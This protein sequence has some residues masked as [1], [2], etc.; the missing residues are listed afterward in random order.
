MTDPCLTTVYDVFTITDIVQEAGQTTEQEFTEPN[1]SAG[2]AV[3]DQT[4]CGA[5]SYQ[6]VK[7]NSLTGF[8]EAQ[9]FGFV[10]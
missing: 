8:E 6:L 5:I 7:V 2:T 3:N 10:E 9:D 4:I 1:H